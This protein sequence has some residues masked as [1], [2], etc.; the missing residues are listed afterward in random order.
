MAAPPRGR[1]REAAGEGGAARPPRP[2]GKVRDHCSSSEPR[3]RRRRRKLFSNFLFSP[4]RQSSA[5]R[6][7][8]LVL[9]CSQWLK[10]C[11]HFFSMQPTP[12][13][14]AAPW[15]PSFGP[16]VV[17]GTQQFRHY[18]KR[19]LLVGSQFSVQSNPTTIVI[20]VQWVEINSNFYAFPAISLKFN[21]PLRIG[22]SQMSYGVNRS[23]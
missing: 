21:L 5:I 17:L 8:K 6:G 7:A 20:V 11:L 14:D 15:C 10:L 3:R 9:Q 13:A 2:R 23:S 12:A 4:F 19:F 1:R 22:L 16:G 18:L